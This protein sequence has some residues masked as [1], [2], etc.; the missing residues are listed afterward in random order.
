MLGSSSP[1][2]MAMPLSSNNEDLVRIKSIV[3]LFM[4]LEFQVATHKTL[5]PYLFAYDTWLHY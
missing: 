5:N 4:S 1:D 3:F 2:K